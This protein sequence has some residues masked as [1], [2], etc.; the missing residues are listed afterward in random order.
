MGDLISEEEFISKRSEYK[1]RELEL[2]LIIDEFEKTNNNTVN[3]VKELLNFG[4]VA[5]DA[6]QNATG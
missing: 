6:F 5:A 4:N 3:N 2:K 1:N